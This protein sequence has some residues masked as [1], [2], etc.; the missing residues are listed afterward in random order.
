MSTSK[1]PGKLF[2]TDYTESDILIV[3]KSFK[4]LTGKQAVKMVINDK[5]VKELEW[6]TEFGIEVASSHFIQPGEVLVYSA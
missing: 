1:L 6:L 5:H 4:D 3:D 2:K